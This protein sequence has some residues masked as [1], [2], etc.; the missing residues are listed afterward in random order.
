MMLTTL[1]L[2]LNTPNCPNVPQPKT[3]TT[4]WKDLDDVAGGRAS[5]LDGVGAATAP[6]VRSGP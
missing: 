1:L 3:I 6:N 5:G 4:N 2:P